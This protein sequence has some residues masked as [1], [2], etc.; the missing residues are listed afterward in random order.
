MRRSLVSLTVIV[1]LCV[2]CQRKAESYSSDVTDVA[3][4]KPSQR[5]ATPPATQAVDATSAASDVAAPAAADATPDTAVRV[6]AG[7]PQLAYSYSYALSLPNDHV[8]DLR[9]RHEAA[10]NAAGFKLCQVVSTSFTEGDHDN[11]RGQL[12]IRAAP[13]WLQGFRNGLAG[14]AKGA[15]G[16]IDTAEVT[17]ED[18]SRDIVDTGAQLRAKTT[19]RDRLQ[20]LLANHPGKVSDLLAVERELARVQGEID[21]AQSEL[22]VMQ[23]RVA[24][25]DVTLKYVASDVLGA[26]VRSPLGIALHDFFQLS[27]TSLAAMISVVAA[28]L[29][30][31]LLAAL[32]AWLFRKRLPGLRWPFRRKAPPPAA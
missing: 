10:C 30:W 24:M 27:A 22:T 13:A 8:N 29:P 25:S 23:G 15:G 20:G 3:L 26:S 31:A 2:G 32:L 14:E 11:S 6:A 21:A 28:L 9:R 7:P 19:L 16:K 18:L 4:I 12:V 1:L 5:A 17:S